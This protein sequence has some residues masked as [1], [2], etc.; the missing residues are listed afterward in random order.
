[1]QTAYPMGPQDPWTPPIRRGKIPCE[2]THAAQFVCGRIVSCFHGR[3]VTV[4]RIRAHS[5]QILLTLIAGIK[6]L[7]SG[8]SVLIRA[9]K[10]QFDWGPHGFA[11]GAGNARS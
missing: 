11:R 9:I 6:H 8:A 10:N 7:A 2:F 3:L 1:M 5:Q 4:K